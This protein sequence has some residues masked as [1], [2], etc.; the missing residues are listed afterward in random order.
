MLVLNQVQLNLN[1]LKNISPSK[2]YNVGLWNKNDQL[3]F[4]VSSQGGDSSLIKPLEYDE[5]IKVKTI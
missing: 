5:K 2:A 3:T 4:Y 1:I